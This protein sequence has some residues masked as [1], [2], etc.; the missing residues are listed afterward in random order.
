METT[1]GELPQVRNW[2]SEPVFYRGQL[3]ACGGATFQARKD[4]G[5]APALGS[6]DWA[7][8]SCA[9][10]DGRDGASVTPRGEWSECD[11]FGVNDIVSIG[12][13]SFIAARNDPGRPGDGNGGWQPL[14]LRGPQG[15]QGRMGPQGAKGE[16]GETVR[17]HSWEVDAPRYRVIGQLTNGEILPPIELRALFEQLLADMSA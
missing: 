4:T 13:G 5:S 8:I 3:A 12:G 14:A 1:P 11:S 7:L 10:K 2:R 6:P 9:G 17:L 16:P 15:K